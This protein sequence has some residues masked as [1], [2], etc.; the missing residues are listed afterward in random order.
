MR[1]KFPCKLWDI[2]CLRGDPDDLSKKAKRA[3]HQIYHRPTTNVL[4]QWLRP[5]ARIHFSGSTGRGREEPFIHGKSLKFERRWGDRL[6]AL[7]ERAIS[8]TPNNN[9]I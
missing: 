8:P 6:K 7:P 4:N 9:S 3:R 5:S 2:S 1:I